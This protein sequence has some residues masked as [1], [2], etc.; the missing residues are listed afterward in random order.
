[1]FE[2]EGLS[3]FLPLWHQAI[4]QKNEGALGW[5][6]LMVALWLKNYAKQRVLGKSFSWFVS[7]PEARHEHSNPLQG[8]P[9][10]ILKM[11]SVVGSFGAGGKAGR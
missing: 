3:K 1:M 10:D 9:L 2:I 5:L 4:P 7:I 8:S 6:F 11:F